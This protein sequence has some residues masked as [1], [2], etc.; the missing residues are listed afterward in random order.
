MPE[1]PITLVDRDLGNAAYLLDLGDG[2]ALAVDPPRDLRAVRRVT[3]ERGLSIA[4][5]A[6]THLH[7]DFLSGAHALAREDGAQVLASRAGERLFPHRGLADGEEVDL[8]GLTLRALSTPGHTGEHLA[9]LVLDGGTEVGVFT[10]GSLL[11]RSAARVDLAGDD[12]VDELA[13]A[14]YRSLRRLAELPDATAVWPTHG[15][16]SFC[17][18]GA[19]AGSATTVGAERA[20]NP[21]LAAPD[22]GTFRVLLDATMGSF[23]PYFRR[24]PE[25]NRRGPGPVEPA[26]E[27]WPVDRVAAH[28][29]DGGLVVDTRPI[30]AF[31]TGHVPGSVSDAWRPGFTAWLGWIADPDRPLVLVRDAATEPVDLGWRARLIGLDGILAELAGGLDAWTAAGRETA[32]L[33]LVG[34]SAAAASGA[35]VV[36][37]RQDREYADRHVAGARHVE[38]G[39]LVDGSADSGW[40]DDPRGLL[41]MCGHGERAMTAASLLRA[42]GHGPV[43]VLAGGPDDLDPR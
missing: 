31:A 10:G 25:V 7:A 37:V 2:R 27:P 11:V 16:G 35:V 15:G 24:L 14:Q 23:P 40:A 19:A 21:L 22:E 41:V 42:A 8:G 30:E 6:D 5:A 18:T 17:S 1:P 38:L 39:D 43:S 33:P 28:L 13:A 12:R 32:T 36:D 20:T 9:F 29:A 4:Y 34:A 26:P 3:A